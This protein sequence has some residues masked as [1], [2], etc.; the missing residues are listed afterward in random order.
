MPL[1]ESLSV[2]FRSFELAPS[3]NAS[4]DWMASL[5]SC[6]FDQHCPALCSLSLWCLS[7]SSV[8]YSIP[9][10]LTELDLNFSDRAAFTALLS[11]SFPAL[12]KL[13]FLLCDM[14]AADVGA[15]LN[16]FP[17]IN[18]IGFQCIETEI[19]NAQRFFDSVVAEAY[20]CCCD[21][22]VCLDVGH[23]PI[24]RF[25]PEWNEFDRIVLARF[26]RLLFQPSF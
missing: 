23:Q 25:S 13:R 24:D 7:P 17:T 20:R 15:V 1:L 21:H 10:T 6:F 5:N 4:A 18:R 14:T 11:H 8:I 26:P 12:R 3:S 16:A 22:S 9:S 2:G 19:A